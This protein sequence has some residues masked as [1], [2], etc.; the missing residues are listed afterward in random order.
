MI[1]ITCVHLVRV[2]DSNSSNFSIVYQYCSI[3]ANPGS[4]DVNTCCWDWSWV[5]NGK[6]L[7]L[8]NTTPVQVEYITKQP[9]QSPLPLISSYIC[10]L[11]CCGQPLSCQQHMSVI[12]LATPPVFDGVRGEGWPGASAVL[13]VI[14]ATLV[15]AQG[16]K[17]LFKG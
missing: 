13:G 12:C 14:T 9:F 5:S 2:N 7:L 10:R 4:I 6:M 11:I 17:H 3:Y 16:Y 1:T 8:N 15:T